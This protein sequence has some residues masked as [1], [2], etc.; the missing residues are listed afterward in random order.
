MAVKFGQF[1]HKYNKKKKRKKTLGNQDI[2]LPMTDE[3]TM[4]RQCDQWEG[5]KENR[6]YRETTGNNSRQMK[7]SRYIKK[8]S[9]EKLT[10]TAHIEKYHA[11]DMELNY[12]NFLCSNVQLTP[13]PK[14]CHFVE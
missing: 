4:H 13:P 12:T 11:T 7:V 14:D 10:H 2:V 8:E 5:S 6:N 9:S 1:H 3:D